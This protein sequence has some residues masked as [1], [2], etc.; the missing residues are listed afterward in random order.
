MV[1]ERPYLIVDFYTCDMAVGI[2]SVFNTNLDLRI[3][4]MD[5]FRTY[6]K[7][8]HADHSSNPGSGTFSND[9]LVLFGFPDGLSVD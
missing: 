3:E 8:N 2:C 4:K 5:C 6:L 7:Q 1:I 9:L